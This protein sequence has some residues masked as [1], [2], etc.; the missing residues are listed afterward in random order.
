ML[1]SVR[2]LAPTA[3]MGGFDA[4]SVPG[5]GANAMM[6]GISG[7]LENQRLR[8]LDRVRLELQQRNQDLQQKRFEETQKY[9]EKSLESLDSYRDMQADT[10]ARRADNSAAGVGAREQDDFWR[11]YI[12]SIELG[13]MP[14]TLE[15][16]RIGRGVTPQPTPAPQPD[17]GG[18]WLERVP[19]FMAQGP[20]PQQPTGSGPMGVTPTPLPEANL[21][22]AIAAL[23]R[24]RNSSADVSDARAEQIGIGNKTLGQRNQAD[25]DYKLAQKVQLD[26]ENEAL[27]E[28]MRARTEKL[29]N[30]IEQSDEKM[31]MQ[32]RE[33]QLR[34]ESLSRGGASRSFS[35]ESGLRK[36][37]TRLAIPYKELEVRTGNMVKALEEI[38]SGGI[39]PS[40]G[41]QILVT[42]FNRM[43][44]PDSVVRESEFARTTQF[45][46]LLETWSGRMDRVAAGGAGLT[47]QER[48][49]LVNSV[50]MMLETSKELYSERAA[51]YRKIAE[52]D[53]LRV[54]HILTPD[55]L[56]S[57]ESPELSE[58][59]AAVKAKVDKVLDAQGI[60]PQ[61]LADAYEE[62]GRAEEAEKIR[63]I[64]GRGR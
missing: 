11:T 47:Q 37:F 19:N 38:E 18:N 52:D 16:F 15:Q 7:A 13:V 56:E 60:T 61:D 4:A 63:R 30:E 12:K 62:K 27:P 22:P 25:L 53:G 36:E 57:P 55:V 23:I 1:R 6:Q 8:G 31:A 20:P 24:Q 9:R 45:M 42:T 48:R 33:L 10:A 40:T 54:D 49:S 14:P 32:A 21:P 41:D 2:K 64:Y 59:D 35:Q 29:F 44:D 5:S 26:I 3:I 43:T 34:E 50:K 28:Y 39:T 46:S 58:Q 17:A 51:M